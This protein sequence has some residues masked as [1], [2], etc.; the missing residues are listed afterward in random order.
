VSRGSRVQ[1]LFVDLDL[2]ASE[3]CRYDFVQLYDG[4][5]SAAR[6]LGKS[7]TS[8]CQ[9]HINIPLIITR[10]SETL[11]VRN[12]ICLKGLSHEIFTVI[13]WLKCI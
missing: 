1:I 6:S 11:T 3:L 13:F 4:P 5:N 7:L 10:H 12:K 2:E 9:R 8:K